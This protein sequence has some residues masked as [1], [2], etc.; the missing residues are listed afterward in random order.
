M[1]APFLSLFFCKAMLAADL[2]LCTNLVKTSKNHLLHQEKAKSIF[3]N[4]DYNPHVLEHM[5]GKE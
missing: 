3:L 5:D 4:G 2:S 1:E